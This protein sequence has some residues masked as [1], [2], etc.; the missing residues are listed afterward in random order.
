MI[1]LDTNVVAEAMRPAPEAAVIDWLNRQDAS[2]IVLSTI[3]IAEISYGLQ[4]LA[5]GQR[6]QML[7]ERFEQ[8]LRRGFAH[9][10]L[11]F[12]EPAALSYGELMA[13]RRG[14]GRPMRVLDGQIA[15]I[16]RSRG[17]ALATRNTSDFDQTAVDLVNPWT[18]R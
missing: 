2:R 9:R 14:I 8:L 15:A 17:F 5:G 11:V 12:D 3:S 6:K 1:L 10:I 16:A 4:C 13:H 18:A 7:A